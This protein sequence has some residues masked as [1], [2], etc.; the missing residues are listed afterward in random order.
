M[1]KAIFQL[2]ARF[3]IHFRS[4]RFQFKSFELKRNS[5]STSQ[6][7]LNRSTPL[8][9]ASESHFQNNDVIELLMESGAGITDTDS[10]GEYALF[11]AI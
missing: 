6:T 8:I 9:I 3:S 10:Y 5:N 2:S 7:S 1:I 4:E 11:Y